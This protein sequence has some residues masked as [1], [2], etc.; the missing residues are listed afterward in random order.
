MQLAKRVTL[1]QHNKLELVPKFTLT[2]RIEETPPPFPPLRPQSRSLTNCIAASAACVPGL[3]L[4]RQAL[5]PLVG[6]VRDLSG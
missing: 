5:A 2:A 1:G 6:V 3:A 4:L